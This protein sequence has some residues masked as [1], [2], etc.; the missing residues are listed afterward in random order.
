MAQDTEYLTEMEII[1]TE[2]KEIAKILDLGRKVTEIA[3][4]LHETL[5]VKSCF[6]F[7]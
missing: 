7:I 3:W 6:K 4:N 5:F 2:A 1:W